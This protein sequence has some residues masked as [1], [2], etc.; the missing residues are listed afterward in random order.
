MTITDPGPA[1]IT[2]YRQS[3]VI[4]CLNGS[5]LTPAVI[6]R[7]QLS[8]VTAINLTAAEI[9]ADFAGTLR[10]LAFVSETVA[11][12]R[13]K[14]MLIRTP[15]DIGEAKR[16]QRIGI[17]LGLQDAEP[18]GRDLAMLRVLT[19]A[20]VRI[21]QLTH[22]R[23]NLIGTGC[24]EPDDGLSR[25]GR[26][27]V[28]EMNRLGLM[29]D[30]SHCGPRTT[31]D[32]IEHSAMPVI[33][34]HANPSAVC[35]SLRNKDDAIIRKLAERGGVIGMACWSPIVYRGDGRRPTLDDMLDCFDYTLRLVGSDH[36]A[37]GTDL[38]EEAIP[39][40][41]AWARVYGP[42]GAFPEVTGGLGSWYGFDTV[43]AEG[44]ETIAA[45]P[46]IAEGLA[47]RGHDDSTIT[48]VLGLNFQRVF[49]HA[50]RR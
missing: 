41:E 39:E 31:L 43:N 42:H 17:I 16:T 7:M 2:L 44:F 34:S 11:A 33:C 4:D 10:G 29:V 5:A 14:L 9:G 3:V 24:V 26:R 19:E 36:V 1:Q 22:N 28:A 20:G 50:C 18:I 40:P 46:G 32:T 15:D 49:D 38:C 23:R 27:V 6:Q 35:L 25:Y 45:L 21:I 37:I 48:K 13:D 8:G 47:R 30:V 12:H